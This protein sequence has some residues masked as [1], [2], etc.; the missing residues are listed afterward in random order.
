MLG[1]LYLLLAVQAGQDCVAVDGRIEGIF[2]VGSLIELGRLYHYLLVGWLCLCGC[3]LGDEFLPELERSDIIIGLS[4]FARSSLH[5]IE[6]LGLL[7]HV[8]GECRPGAVL[9]RT[10]HRHRGFHLNFIYL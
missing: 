3:V 9:E 4:V 7:E 5:F 2:G 8:A 6:I 10:H 1:D